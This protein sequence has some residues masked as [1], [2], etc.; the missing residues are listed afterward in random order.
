MK[1]RDAGVISV[2]LICFIAFSG[3]GSTLMPATHTQQPPPA[4]PSTMASTPLIASISP[5]NAPS[6]SAD[7]TVKITGTNFI[8]R[9]GHTQSW[10]TWVVNTNET[11]L[12]KMFVS[13]T[14]LTADVP[15]SLLTVPVTAQIF[16][17][18]GDIMGASDGVKYP[19]SNR[20]PFTVQ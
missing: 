1:T 8:K 12:E 5:S 20:V 13:S 4:T 10:A 9:Q 7:V 11:F 15:A 6:Q 14:E 18:N 17:E 3:W 16:V 19:E 2:L